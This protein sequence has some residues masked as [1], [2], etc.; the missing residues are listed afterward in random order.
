[1][2]LI[3]VFKQKILALSLVFLATLVIG[4]VDPSFTLLA[5]DRPLSADRP[6]STESPNTV[7]RG[8]FQ[9]ETSFA[10][11]TREDHPDGHGES[12]VFA[13]TNFKFGLTDHTDLQLVVA[14]YVHEREVT[15]AGVSDTDDFGDVTLRLK[16]NLWGNDEGDTAF[17]LLPYVKFPLQTSVTNGR[18]EGGLIVPFAWDLTDRLSLGAQVEVA[19]AYDEE[20]GSYW[21]F[22][23]T[24]VLGAALTDRWG[25]YLE[26]AG[27]QSELPYESFASAGMTY[28]VNDDL[29]LDIGGL[30]GLNEDTNSFSIFTGLTVRY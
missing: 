4:A 7:P 2:K 22:G 15:A 26:Y 3:F 13:E 17:G 28:L 11:Y 21:A 12:W 19:N 9:L 27:T 1:M 20:V 25:L 18:W 6:D 8:R 14:P 23:H 30:L 29:Q 10:A 5:Q 24:V 16:W